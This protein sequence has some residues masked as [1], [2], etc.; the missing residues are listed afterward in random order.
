MKQARPSAEECGAKFTPGPWI[1]DAVMSEIEVDVCIGYEV[2]GT[3]RPLVIASAFDD[4][5]DGDRDGWPISRKAAIANARLIAAAP[6]LLEA[7]QALLLDINKGN[8]GP[9]S[10]CKPSVVAARAAIAKA[11]TTP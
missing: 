10:S 6:D 7:C 1:A 11:T 9:V 4:S 8:I 3:G 2:P 5:D